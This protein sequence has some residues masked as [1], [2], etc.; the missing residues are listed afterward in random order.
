[1]WPHGEQY[2]PNEAAALRAQ[3]AAVEAAARTSAA[4]SL[5]L[6]DVAA[7]L[8]K[9]VDAPPAP[10]P[11]PLPPPAPQPPPPAPRASGATACT[12]SA[13]ASPPAP[14]GLPEVFERTLNPAHVLMFVDWL[15]GGGGYD[16]DDKLMRWTTGTVRIQFRA[17]RQTW[18]TSR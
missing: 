4:Q 9:V 2:E 10:P 12:G 16:R 6:F 17:W 11:A 18:A 15:E 1:M 7:A 3:I 14:P 8:T 5:A 13:C